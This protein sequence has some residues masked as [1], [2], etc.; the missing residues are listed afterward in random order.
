VTLL[1]NLRDYLIAEGL[2]RAPNAPGPGPRPWLPPVWRHPD[3]GAVAPGDAADQG[4]PDAARDDGLVVSLMHAP[5]IPPRAGEEERRID[6]VDVVFRG[7]AVA[8]IFDLERAIR[9]RL[10]GTLDPGGRADWVMAGLYVIQ[11]RQWSPM[12]P[13]DAVDGTF[14]FRGGYVIERRVA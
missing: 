3:N 1:D 11:S 2:V 5:G 4:R 6:G 14:T 8:P 9:D 13:V 12:Q 10:V 7:T